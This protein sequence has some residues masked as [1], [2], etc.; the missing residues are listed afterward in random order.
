MYGDGAIEACAHGHRHTLI[1]AAWHQ[2]A[3]VAFGT[4]SVER[5]PPDHADY[6]P[7]YRPDLGIE[8]AGRNEQY[9][10]LD[11]KCGSPFVAS[12]TVA[13]RVRAE[14]TAFA[15]T[16][17]RFITAVLGRAARGDGP[18]DITT[19]RGYVSPKAA[20]Y[21]GALARGHDPRPLI[22][23]TFGGVHPDALKLLDAWGG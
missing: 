6:S 14:H 2:A 10:I 23:E 18:F 4:A 5:E 7:H 3:V 15:G 13:E 16:A 11:T 12:H 21:R 19:G 20:D 9:L 22:H 8:E 17:E 1:L